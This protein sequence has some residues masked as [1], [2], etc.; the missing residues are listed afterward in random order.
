MENKIDL[1]TLEEVKST[2]IKNV[3]ALNSEGNVI[4]ADLSNV[5][6]AVNQHTDDIEAVIFE[7]NETNDSVNGIKADLQALE[8]RVDNIPTTG[9]TGEVT[10]EEYEA[11]NT[12]VNGI[13]ADLQA[14]EERVDNIPTTGGT[15]DV[16]RE[17]FEELDLRVEAQN[18]R[19][20]NVEDDVEKIKL[21]PFNIDTTYFNKL[22]E[23]MTGN[24]VYYL[25]GETKH[26]VR[27]FAINGKYYNPL[28]IFGLTV[29]MGVAEDL[30]VIKFN[31]N[32]DDD[33][34]TFT[35]SQITTTPIN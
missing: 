29:F 33:S 3:V 9:G 34:V 23:N 14:L 1:R 18:A 11:L 21:N 4:K 28:Y 7:I 2:E 12:S 26:G 6:N 8:E 31:I 25:I 5:I 15:G 30:T 17:E 13:K 24:D 10:R 16:T 35:K 20:S 19:L 22:E 32:I 27:Q